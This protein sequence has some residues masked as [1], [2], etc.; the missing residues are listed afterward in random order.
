MALL[1]L[2]CDLL[3]EPSEDTQFDLEPRYLLGIW[4]EVKM[5]EATY[6]PGHY[7]P[8]TT[9][10]EIR[11]LSSEQDFQLRNLVFDHGENK[12]V[13]DPL[14]FKI[15]FKRGYISGYIYCPECE[16]NWETLRNRCTYK[17]VQND[18]P[19]FSEVSFEMPNTDSL[20][21]TL[22][23]HRFGLKKAR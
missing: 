18:P 19:E 15:E 4:L 17:I 13:I 1:C 23:T 3:A 21:V 20:C 10:Y 2:S 8:D 14:T 9:R 6:L 5:V 22:G 7:V 11:G 12:P 16:T